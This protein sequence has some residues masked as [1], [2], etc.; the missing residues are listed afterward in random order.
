[1]PCSR[2][3][4]PLSAFR[5]YRRLLLLLGRFLGFFRSFGPDRF[6]A[7]PVRT[8]FRRDLAFPL[9]RLVGSQELQQHELAVIAEPTLGQDG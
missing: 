5:P 8:A 4:E 1:M 2:L 3:P 9:H 7:F 6:L